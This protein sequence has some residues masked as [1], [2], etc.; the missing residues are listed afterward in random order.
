MVQS[1]GIGEYSEG[2]IRLAK[3]REDRDREV[4]K[5]LRAECEFGLRQTRHIEKKALQAGVFK[6]APLQ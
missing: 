1:S 5:Q 3:P 6:D 2:S 4:V